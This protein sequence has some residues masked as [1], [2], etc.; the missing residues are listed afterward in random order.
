MLRMAD[1]GMTKEARGRTSIAPVLPKIKSEHPLR[2]DAD[3][4]MK[5]AKNLSLIHI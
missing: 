3:V 4:W 2:G 5:V 1:D